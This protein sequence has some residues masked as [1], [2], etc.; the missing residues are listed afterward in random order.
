MAYLIEL[1]SFTDIRGRLT[2]MDKELPFE[3]KRLY[4]I[5]EVSEESERG[6]HAHHLTKEAIFCVHGSF[7]VFINNGKKKEEF[8]LNDYTQCLI[9]E[10]FDW[11]LVYNFS[12]GAILMGVSSTHYDHSD[13]YFEEPK[14]L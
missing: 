9:V 2:V 8:L 3:F 4:Y 10:P 6:G 11:H 14:I 1:K 7:T 13:Y 12:P 5:N